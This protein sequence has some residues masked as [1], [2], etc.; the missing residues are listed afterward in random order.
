MDDLFS[1]ISKTN[2]EIGQYIVNELEKNG[3]E[4]LAL[5]HGTILISLAYDKALNYKD[6][7]KKTGK[8]Q[9][10]ITT[11]VRKLIKEGYVV[12]T[13]DE[14]DKRNKIV[15]LSNKGEEFIPLMMKISKGVY[16]I[17]YKGFDFEEILQVRKLLEKIKGNFQRENE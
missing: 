13:V 7:S 10:T 16:E 1:L 11:L 8:T 17:Q 5:S 15:S 2:A 9:Q 4:G 12:V 14:N 3:V 6:L